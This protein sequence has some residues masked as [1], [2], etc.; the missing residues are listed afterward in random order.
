MNVVAIGYYRPGYRL[1][2]YFDWRDAFLGLRPR[3][4]VRVI[5]AYR[6]L[7]PP[8]RFH[9]R[10]PLSWSRPVRVYRELY[11]GEIP[12][13]LL[14]LLPSFFHFHKGER[15]ASVLRDLASRSRKR[16]ET[17]F[18]MENE[19]RSLAEKVDLATALRADVL[20]SQLPV[21]VARPF[22]AA[23]FAGTV[24]S[25]PGALNPEVFRP[26]CCLAER[27]IDVGTRSHVYPA[28]LGD[29]E[30][31]ALLDLFQRGEGP[32]AGLK[33]DISVDQRHR[34]TRHGWAAFLNA[35]RTTVS[36]E[37]GAVE[38]AWSDRPAVRV[39]GKAV[40]SR[41][42][43][44]IGT[45]TAQIMFAGRFSE[46][47]AA[48]GRALHRAQTRLQQPRRGLRRRTRRQPAGAAHQRRARARD[49]RPHLCASGRCLDE[50]RLKAR[51]APG[52][53]DRWPERDRRR[54]RT[55]EWLLP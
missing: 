14:V 10:L 34:F 2:Y 44:A 15:M 28:S 30:R 48:R 39:S 54:R 32:T 20:V 21:D 19:Y 45:R 18:F 47:H 33:R 3:H 36:T 35:C 12:C 9:E 11:A 13:D 26:R 5:N 7:P 51:L 22:Y 41:H 37:A 46:R 23:R 38:L 8:Y 29:G 43:E 16:F 50:G 55:G 31:N 42:F 27:P 4:R 49:D 1:A 24:V 25:L 6:F 17:V 40:A 53:G 52:R